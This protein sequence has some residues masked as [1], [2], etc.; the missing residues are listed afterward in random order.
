LGAAFL[1]LAGNFAYLKTPHAGLFLRESV[2]VLPMFLP[3]GAALIFSS[4]LIQWA[5][6][7]ALFVMMAG[8]TIA[9]SNTLT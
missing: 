5:C 4:R 8:F 2:G 3:I 1:S 7:I 6:G 9:F